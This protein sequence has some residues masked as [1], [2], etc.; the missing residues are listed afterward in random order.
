MRRAPPNPQSRVESHRGTR[1]VSRNG[2][3]RRGVVDTETGRQVMRNCG[4]EREL[5]EVAHAYRAVYALRSAYDREPVLTV[6]AAIAYGELSLR[7][8]RLRTLAE[9]AAS[10]R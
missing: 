9:P 6:S 5:F 7:M 2:R 1:K 4:G 10:A 3:E 8:D